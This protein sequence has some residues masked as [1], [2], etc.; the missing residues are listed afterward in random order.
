LAGPTSRYSAPIWGA[1]LRLS[2]WQTLPTGH[3]NV[4]LAFRLS[5]VLIALAARGV[6]DPLTG[7]LAQSAAVFV[8]VANSARILR[9]GTPAIRPATQPDVMPVVT[10]PHHDSSTPSS[11][12]NRGQFCYS[13]PQL[14]R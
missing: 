4:W 1:F 8:V 13:A 14:C 7:A 12:S 11:S 2:G 6:L 5:V 3:C 10:D 9:F